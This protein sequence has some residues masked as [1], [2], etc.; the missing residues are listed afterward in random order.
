MLRGKEKWA[1]T[2]SLDKWEDG[3]E[4][5]VEQDVEIVDGEIPARLEKKEDVKQIEG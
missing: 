2:P 3:E 5:E 1:P 4:Y